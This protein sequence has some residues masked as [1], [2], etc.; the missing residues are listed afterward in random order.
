MSPLTDVGVTVASAAAVSPLS[1]L[2]A[3][4]RLAHPGVGELTLTRDNVAIDDRR[5]LRL[6]FYHAEPGTD[7]YARLQRLGDPAAGQPVR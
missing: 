6:V 3:P 5:R 1:H 2:H 4:V 7:S